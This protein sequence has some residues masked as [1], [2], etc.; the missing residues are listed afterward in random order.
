MAVCVKQTFALV[1]AEARAAAAA[2]ATFPS[3]ISCSTF[4]FPASFSLSLLASTFS[5][6]SSASFSS[7]RDFPPSLLRASS[8][9][10]SI[11]VG[12]KLHYTRAAVSQTN[13]S[14][15]CHSP[16]VQYCCCSK[17]W[18]GNESSLRG[19]DPKTGQL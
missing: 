13:P 1:A 16:T 12:Q 11:G 17:C 18:R 7:G 5:L 6:F 3:E 15:R 14:P 4:F 10:N 19:S 8:L 2:V 9:V